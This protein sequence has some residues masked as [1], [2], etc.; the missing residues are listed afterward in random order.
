MDP[1]SPVTLQSIR[2]I[3]TGASEGTPYIF[4]NLAETIE[5]LRIARSKGAQAFDTLFRLEKT[6]APEAQIQAAQRA[7][8]RFMNEAD[9]LQLMLNKMIRG[10]IE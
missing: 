1:D 8:N 6:G 4:E 3:A 9:D 2:D 5:N 7:A 10:T